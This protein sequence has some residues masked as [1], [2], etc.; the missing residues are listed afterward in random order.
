MRETLLQYIETLSDGGG[1]AQEIVEETVLRMKEII[2]DTLMSA[3]VF[4]LSFRNTLGRAIKRRN[5]SCSA[6]IS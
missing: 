5:F 6:M 3:R 2:M 4:L 1:R